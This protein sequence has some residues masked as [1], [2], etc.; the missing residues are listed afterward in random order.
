MAG[1][2]LPGL[3]AHLLLWGLQWVLSATCRSGWQGSPL[4]QQLSAQGSLSFGDWGLLEVAPAFCF[5]S[6]LARSQ[7]GAE[8]MQDGWQ[9]RV[10]SP[11]SLSR[12]S[13][14]CLNFRPRHVWGSSQILE[15]CG[16]SGARK[17]PDWN[18]HI[19]FLRRDSR[20]I[21]KAQDEAPGI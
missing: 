21:Q 1:S 20:R 13:P 4:Q 16:Q 17:S 8:R 15:D 11:R 7:Q 6:E 12:V 5:T 2:S 14:G 10:G 9:Q 18:Q 3:A 19:F